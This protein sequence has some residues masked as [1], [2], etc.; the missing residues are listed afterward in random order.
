MNVRQ[1]EILAAEELDRA[2]FRG[3]VDSI[4]GRTIRGWIYDSTAPLRHL[5]VDLFVDGQMVESHVAKSFREDLARAGYGDGEYAFEFELPKALFDDQPHAVIVRERDEGWC[6]PGLADELILDKSF[7]SDCAGA[8]VGIRD[9]QI[10]GFACDR[11]DRDARCDVVLCIGDREVAHAVAN[12]QLPDVMF[13]AQAPADCGFR[14][15]LADLD[16]ADLTAPE[17]AIRVRQD[18]FVLGY[19]KDLVRELT[20]LRV[21]KMT[22]GAIW[23][24]L[25]IA[26]TPRKLTAF[27]VLLDG[28]PTLVLRVGANSALRVLPFRIATDSADAARLHTLSV[29]FAGSDFEVSESPRV[30]AP[31]RRNV[32]S[33]GRFAHWAGAEPTGWS[34]EAP[35]GVS[36]APIYQ[37]TAVVEGAVLGPSAIA[38][39]VADGESTL[40]GACLRQRLALDADCGQELELMVGGEADVR[41]ECRLAIVQTAA[42]GSVAEASAPIILGKRLGLRRVSFAMPAAGNSTAEITLRVEGGDP[43]SLQIALIAAGLPGFV[44]DDAETAVASDGETPASWSA[45]RNGDF[46]LWSKPFRQVI[47]ERRVETADGWVVASKRP[48]PAME[49]WLTD[50]LTRDTKLAREGTPAYGIAILGDVTGDYVR[51]ETSLDQLPLIEGD[52]QRLS[53]FACAASSLR[54]VAGDTRACRI[55]EVFIIDR[56]FS[57][58]DGANSEFTDSKLLSIAKNLTIQSTGELVSLQLSPRDKEVLQAAAQEALYGA[59]HR[60]LVLVFEGAGKADWVFADVSFGPG[61]QSEA[62]NTAAGYVA[63]EDSNLVSQLTLVKGIENWGQPVQFAA[64]AVVEP[65]QASAAHVEI[66]W[67]WPAVTAQTVE[68]VICVHDAVDETLACLDALRRCTAIPHT[69]AVIDDDSTATTREQLRRY[70]AGAPW[71]RLVAFDRHVGYTKAANAGMSSSH[72][73]WLVLLNSDTIV[74]PG[75]LEGL[76]EVAATA[77]NAA[78]VGPLSNAASW[79]SVPDL[80]DGRGDWKIN[81]IP[82]GWSIDELAATISQLSGKQFPEVP[83][84]NGFCTL[85]NRR[86][87]EQVGF[88]DELAFPLGYGEEND[89][90]IRLRKAGYKLYIADH[91]YVYHHKSAS[92]GHQQRRVLSKRGTERLLVK[93]PD[94]DVQSLQR[95]MAEVTALIDLRKALR[96]RLAET[97][98][99]RDAAW[100]VS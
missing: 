25:H 10:W 67:Q 5:I 54:T 71:I 46:R 19:A 40:G 83:L 99:Y 21:N 14:L 2:R 66:K 27:D 15:D 58:D 80:H 96:E 75:W 44:L 60:D 65:D 34:V 24:A 9:G 49:A 93:H 52:P 84:L 16:V 45:V 62:V 70:I 3:S 87:L 47:D 89:L 77:P 37:Q 32:V 17:I 97:G 39:N 28:A 13:D 35:A 63:L 81:P 43:K 56:R 64:G 73:D 38:F 59:H 20:Q 30:L 91:V 51:L 98:G 74:T 78:M 42:D 69:I 95:A 18:G 57:A 90:C 7:N 48:N 100:S 11:A 50:V 26:F 94:V 41:T 68:V 72:A 53:F 61:P 29:R 1:P 79:Q 12:E 86:A 23:G 36:V 82:D 8:L 92:F 6:I 31:P 88:L 33:N 85:I 4:E 76:L 55:R 22:D